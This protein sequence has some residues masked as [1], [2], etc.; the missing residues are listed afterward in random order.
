MNAKRYLKVKM[1]NL[2]Q[3]IEALLT[4]AELL[5]PGTF[6]SIASDIDDLTDQVE[7]LRKDIQGKNQEPKVGEETEDKVEESTIS[8]EELFREI[9]NENIK[10]FKKERSTDFNLLKK[11]TKQ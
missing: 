11:K 5:G 4:K 6:E 1:L 7:K 8:L 3:E 2:Q 10:D 9:T